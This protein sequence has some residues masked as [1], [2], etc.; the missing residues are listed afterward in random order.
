MKFFVFFVLISINIFAADDYRY[1]DDGSSSYVG[2]CILHE[3]YENIAFSSKEII[4][5]TNYPTNDFFNKIPKLLK[6]LAYYT[7]SQEIAPYMSSETDLEGFDDISFDFVYLKTSKNIYIRVSYGVGGGNGGYD[8][9]DVTDM[10]N[11][12]VVTRTFDGEL[13]E[14]NL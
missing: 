11:I 5:Y 1:N 8:T 4:P 2:S 13:L 9:Y 10:D 12:K 3:D 14:C 7:H 6:K